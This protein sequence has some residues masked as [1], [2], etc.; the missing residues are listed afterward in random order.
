MLGGYESL[1]T[2]LISEDLGEMDLTY[3]FREEEL[4]EWCP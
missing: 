4:L 3:G 2:I 1:K